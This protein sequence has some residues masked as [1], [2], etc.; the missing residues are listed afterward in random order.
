MYNDRASVRQ[1]ATFAFGAYRLGDLSML[2]AAAF[3]PGCAVVP[4]AVAGAGILGVTPGALVA[5][6]LLSAAFFKS[7]QVCLFALNYLLFA[8]RLTR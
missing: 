4:E 6:G 8:L 7:S 2:T 1:N 3:A 5:G